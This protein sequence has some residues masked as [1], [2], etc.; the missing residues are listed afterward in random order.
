MSARL[1]PDSLN[2]ITL[3]MSIKPQYADLIL[4][5]QKTIEL[6]RVRPKVQQGDV[7][8]IYAS[9]PRMALLGGFEVEGLVSDTPANV[10]KTH[11]AASGVTRTVFD[12]YFEG[13]TLAHGIKIARS[14]RLSEA[15]ELQ[16]L[17]KKVRGFR[18]PQSYCYLDNNQ[19]TCL[20][21]AATKVQN[22]TSSARTA[23]NSQGSV[24]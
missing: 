14:W 24:R 22:S 8:L 10:Y 4:N 16:T 19:A 21:P 2:Q 9:G 11:G 23:V 20:V 6:R 7:V 12:R 5:G 3:L 1:Q 15:T 13:S 17:R 18:P